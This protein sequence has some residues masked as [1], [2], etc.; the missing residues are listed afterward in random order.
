MK[1][2]RLDKRYILKIMLNRLI[3]TII[4]NIVYFVG[5]TK[6]PNEKF[7]IYIATALYIINIIATFVI[8]IMPFIEFWAYKYFISSDAIEIRYGVI[9]RKSVYIPRENIKYIIA[10]KD[11][12][13][14]L[15]MISSLKIYTTAGHRII[16]ALGKKNMLILWNIMSIS[17]GNKE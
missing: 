17:E 11:P 10:V 2:H 7:E 3:V 1:G 4:L 13:D 12:I 9:F 5:K 15:L 14:R 8:V 6:L 16:K